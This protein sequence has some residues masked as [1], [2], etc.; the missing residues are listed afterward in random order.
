VDPLKLEAIFE[1]LGLPLPSWALKGLLGLVAL[2]IVI[3][4]AERSIH[5][6]NYIRSQDISAFVLTVWAADYFRA[7]LNLKFLFGLVIAIWAVVISVAV[8]RLNDDVIRYVV[9]RRLSEPQKELIAKRLQETKPHDIKFQVAQGDREASNYRVDLQQALE[10]GRWPV[11]AI[12]YSRDLQDGLGIQF[13]RPS[14]P[15]KTA[16]ENARER[17]SG[18]RAPEADNILREVFRE[19]GIFIQ[20]GGGS[21][22][23]TATLTI[24]I[25]PRPR[26]YN[27]L[28]RER[29]NVL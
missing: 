22:G 13:S 3:S 27:A 11:I 12:S 18:S 10:K 28:P 16:E 6:V 19:A 15:T 20:H 2:L 25:G 17:V 4:L 26:D 8:W 9:P 29:R 7:L 14:P 23:E 1:R 5:Y 24:Q 21:T